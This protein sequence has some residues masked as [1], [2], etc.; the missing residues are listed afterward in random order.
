MNFNKR[1]YTLLLLALSAIL[2]L[3][4]GDDE[5][6]P[7]PTDQE[8]ALERLE[9]QW[10]FGSS[11]G[12][13]RDG[14]DVSLNYP[15]FSLSFTAGTYQTQNGGDLFSTSGTWQWANDEARLISLDSG[16]QLTISTLTETDFQFSFTFAGSGGVAA[17]TSG[18]Y[19]VTLE[20]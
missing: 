6:P 19:V 12:I 4:C 11:G 14:Q 17:G 16:V 2:F 3:N 20:K 7:Q 8:M 10:T 13:T 1:T 5:P 15:G 9:G 18:V